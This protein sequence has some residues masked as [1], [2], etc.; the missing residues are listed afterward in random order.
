MRIL[1]INIYNKDCSQVQSFRGE[2]NINT[3]STLYSSGDEF[4]N[5]ISSSIL[6][7]HNELA[8]VIFKTPISPYRAIWALA[9]SSDPNV[10]QALFHKMHTPDE[11]EEM[12]FD[13][14]A[15]DFLRDIKVKKLIGLGA[16]AFAFET[17][18]GKILKIT[19]G[20]HFHNKRKPD[21][22]DIP[23]IHQGRMCRTYYYL[24]DKLSQDDLTQEELKNLVKQIEEKGYILR[25]VYYSSRYGEISDKV[26][27]EQFG[28]AKDGKIY[29]LDAGCV[30]PPDKPLIDIKSIIGKLKRLIKLK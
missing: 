19:N 8:E 26:K 22:F 18:D 3:T 10:S 1:P 29:L 4:F 16:Y 24:E 2:K 9:K 25:D 17:E 23:I 12:A 6:K 5:C 13:I 11:L 14:S 27:P 21:F 28:R 30:F 15:S 7:K 20:N